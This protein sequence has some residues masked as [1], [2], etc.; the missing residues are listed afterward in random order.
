MVHPDSNRD[1]FP[2][3][4]MRKVHDGER[5]R[6]SPGWHLGQ[7]QLGKLGE[8]LSPHELT[9]GL[10]REI[11]CAIVAFR[12]N[13]L[14]KQMQSYIN[15][16]AR[17]QHLAR[18]KAARALLELLDPTPPGDDDLVCALRWSIF[19]WQ[20]AVNDLMPRNPRNRPVDDRMILLGVAVVEALD[21]V[22]I[23]LEARRVEST[24]LMDALHFVR[25]CAE[26]SL[27]DLTTAG[28]YALTQKVLKSYYNRSQK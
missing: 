8:A 21:R 25:G 26:P 10:V 28:T 19:A 23:P 12:K 4:V 6:E 27:P 15:E 11:E 22:A 9:P 5:T 7:S 1:P 2:V 17:P 20:A 24:P 3:S 14:V 16:H 18:L 13:G